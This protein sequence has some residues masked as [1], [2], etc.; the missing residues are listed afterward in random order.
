MCRMARPRKP[1]LSR[2]RIVK[3]ASALVDAEGL[4]A[5]ST[6]R[7][8]LSKGLRGRAMAHIVGLHP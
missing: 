7:S 3:T 2:E 4:D 1:L 8:V 5:V 6:M